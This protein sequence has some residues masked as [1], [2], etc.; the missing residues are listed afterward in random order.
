MA[1]EKMIS[2]EFFQTFQNSF[3]M[4]HLWTVAWVVAEKSQTF[5]V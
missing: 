1:L 4:E 3:F 5:T 2:R